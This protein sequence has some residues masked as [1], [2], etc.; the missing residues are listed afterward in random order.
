LEWVEHAIPFGDFI[1]DKGGKR[2]NVVGSHSRYYPGEWGHAR[3]R[4]HLN[5]AEQHE[6]RR[7]FDEICEHHSPAFRFF[8][9]E[10]FGNSLETWY[11]AK[12]RYTRSVAVSSI[13]GHILGI[14]DR[15][16][17]NILVHQKTGEVV[18]ID[19]G[20]VFEQGKVR[21]FFWRKLSNQAN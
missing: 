4:N 1:A 20:I 14:G 19:F 6:K 2:G 7:A 21:Y 18:H 3:C 12:M 17:S 11:A 15:H 8:F 5:T 13:V 9:V 10:R 16:T